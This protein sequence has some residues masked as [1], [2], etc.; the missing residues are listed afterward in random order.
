MNLHLVTFSPTHTS[1]TIAEQIAQGFALSEDTLQTTDLTLP[2]RTPE[3]IEL[4]GVAVFAAPV[5]GGR[6]A[7]PAAERF[8]HIHAAKTGGTPAIVAV[9]YGNRDYEDALLELCDL[10]R[11]QGFRPIAA[12]AF[13]GEHSYSRPNEGMPIA[14][15]RPDPADCTCAQAFGR[16]AREKYDRGDTTL[17]P[18]RGNYPY[19]IKGAA[20]PATPITL[21]N[22]C[23]GC[24]TCVDICPTG[25]VSLTA[26]GIATSTADGCIK[27]CACLKFCPAAARRFDTPYTERLFLNFSARREPE[28][29]L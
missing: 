22:Q 11:Q 3:M 14:A 13:I 6:V 15:G 7:E 8:S 27:C 29:F 19:K 4:D 17:P 12:G 23:T 1:R 9:V 28:L 25:V 16:Q 26:E 18:V 20:T 24:G 5:Y 2:G 10:V 21:P